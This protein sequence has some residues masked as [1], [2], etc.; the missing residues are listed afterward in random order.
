MVTSGTREE[1]DG[2]G[3]HGTPKPEA[4]LGFQVP[5]LV[6]LFVAHR[7]PAR[8]A[9]W[10]GGQPERGHSSV[11]PIVGTREGEPACMVAG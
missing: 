3:G 6:L 2:T 4:L 1:P 11:F 5:A 9:S 8:T 10:A 7:F